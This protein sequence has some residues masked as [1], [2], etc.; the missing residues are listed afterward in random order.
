MNKKILIILI[1]VIVLTVVGIILY[2]VLSRKSGSKEIE[3]TYKISAGIPYRWEF[4]IE[5]DS[6]VGFVKSYVLK[7]ENVGGKVGAP[8]Y[9]NYVF[10]GLK[11]GVT[12]VTFKFVNISRDNEVDSTEKH[13]LKVDKDL[14]ISLVA[15]D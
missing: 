9:T 13:K 6:I 8:V 7:D 15:V 4:E 11:E 12:T 2:K 14:N 1:M 5:D 3:L 10:K